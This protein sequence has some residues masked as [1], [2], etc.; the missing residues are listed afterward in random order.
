MDSQVLQNNQSQ[1]SQQLEQPQE[2]DQAQP[3]VKQVEPKPHSQQKPT[4]YQKTDNPSINA[5]LGIIS[6]AGI[7]PSNSVVQAALNGDTSSLVHVMRYLNVE[8]GEV[9]V[10]LLEQV[11]KTRQEQLSQEQAKAV[12]AI[13]QS[14]GGKE[15]WDIMQ[16]FAKATYSPEDL[17]ELIEDLDAGG[18]VAQLRVKELHK[19]FKEAGGKV[20]EK[21]QPEEETPINPSAQPVGKGEKLTLQGYIKE[22]NALYQKGIV[23][24]SPEMKALQAKY[25]GIV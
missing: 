9:A 6:R 1:P 3:D 14:V 10:Q 11:H 19:V 15:Q 7:D 12:E 5:A 20:P 4:S 17:K 25:A 24:S 2:Q 8:D 13:Y 16:E 21:A 23:S 18:R 22:R